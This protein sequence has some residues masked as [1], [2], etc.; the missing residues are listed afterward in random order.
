M[1]QRYQ[2]VCTEHAFLF[3][4]QKHNFKRKQSARMKLASPFPLS[5]VLSDGRKTTTH[6][7]DITYTNAPMEN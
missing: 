2:D 5:L 1:N 7:S 4:P 3:Q 6:A